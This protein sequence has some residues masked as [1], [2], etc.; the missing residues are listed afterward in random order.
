MSALDFLRI[1]KNFRVGEMMR[2]GPVRSRLETSGLSFTEFSYQILQSFDWFVL[3]RR[4]DCFFQIGG[5]DQL[6]HLDSGADYI[7]RKTGR[8]AVGVCLPLLT[9]ASGNKLGKST[10]ADKSPVWLCSSKTSPFALFQYFR[11]LHDDVAEELLIYYSLRPFEEVEK[12]IQHHGENLGKCIAQQALAEEIV[13]LVHGR[14]D[15]EKAITCSNVLFKGSLNDFERLDHD[16]ISKVF[17]GPL[18][19]QLSKNEI[20]KVAHLADAIAP[21]GSALVKQ[22]SFK[23]N[24]MKITDPEAIIDHGFLLKNR[25][26]LITWGKRSFYLIDWRD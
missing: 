2:M 7:K 18:T 9:D 4:F 22:G 20:T 26:S 8:Q 1:G 25:Y 12:I 17:A 3:S 19:V 6:G 23:L 5:S 21:K 14:S 24:G 16:T 11:Q 13:L 15:L 10:A